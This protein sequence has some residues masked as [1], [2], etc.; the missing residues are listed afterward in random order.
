MTK[1]EYLNEFEKLLNKKLKALSYINAQRVGIQCTGDWPYD[2][3][4]Q[5]NDYLEKIIKLIDSLKRDYDP[6]PSWNGIKLRK[7]E[8][9]NEDDTQLVDALYAKILI[10]IDN[11]KAKNLIDKA[12]YFPLTDEGEVDE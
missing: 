6:T 1:E 11:P 9:E 4:E 3:F 10:S 12:C 2:S 5:A 7:V 8:L